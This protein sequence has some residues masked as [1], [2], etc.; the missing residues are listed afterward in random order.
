MGL[1]S[2]WYL[3]QNREDPDHNSENPEDKEWIE[4]I[5]KKELTAPLDKQSGEGKH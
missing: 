3:H 5:D 1:Q 2:T 4:D